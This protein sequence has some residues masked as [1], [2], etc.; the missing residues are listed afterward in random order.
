MLLCI[1]STGTCASVCKNIIEGDG[2]DH[3]L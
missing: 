3:K 1:I 2:V